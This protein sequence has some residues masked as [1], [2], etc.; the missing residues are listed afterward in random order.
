MTEFI[1][2]LSGKKQGA[3]DFANSIISC[4]LQRID[5]ELM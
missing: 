1:E 5:E 2:N 4:R 3:K